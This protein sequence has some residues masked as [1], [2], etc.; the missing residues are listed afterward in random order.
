MLNLVSNALKYRSQV[1]PVITIR[2]EEDPAHWKFSIADNGM[3]IEPR[4]FD[5]IFVIFQRLNN[6]SEQRGSGLGLAICKKIVEG[7]KGSI[8]VESNTDNGSTF[9]F[10]IAQKK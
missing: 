9:H 8:W 10:T 6:Q 4:F 5:K 3:G 2:V 7:H 1:A